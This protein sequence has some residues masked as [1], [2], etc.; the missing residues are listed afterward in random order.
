VKLTDRLVNS[1]RVA[2]GR[3]G[4]PRPGPRS[5]GRDDSRRRL[6]A[7]AAR[8]F[9]THGFAGA[10]VD[11]IAAT[12]RL[13]KAM[14]YYHFGSK[15]GLHGE[16]LRDMFRAA[17]DSVREIAASA[18]SPEEKVR[19]FVAAIAVAADARPHFPPIWFREIADGGIHLDP[20]TI[21]EVAGIVSALS[22]FIDAGVRKGVFRPVDPFLVHAGIVAPLLLFFASEPLR[23]RMSRAGLGVS[24]YQRG[25]VVDHIQR[26]TLGVL[27]GLANGQADA[28]GPR[29]PTGRARGRRGGQ[30]A[31]PRSRRTRGQSSE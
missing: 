26:V 15:A 23:E 1:R 8:E 19:R 24:Q 28:V 18:D 25:Q 12:A 7:A 16:I 27:R 2:G 4:P 31:R 13:N 21:R 10:S 14:I 11:R 29:A 20:Q 30:P 22:G 3:D 5:R 6:F 9:A 17:G